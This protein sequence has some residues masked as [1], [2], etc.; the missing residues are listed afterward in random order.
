MHRFLMIL[1]TALV[2]AVALPGYA[3]D[4]PPPLPAVPS[5][6][7]VRSLDE[8]VALALAHAP[9]LQAG[10]AGIGAAEGDRLQA[11]LL[12][13]PEFSIQAENFA[14][15]SNY[16]GFRSAESTIGLAQRI[17]LGGKRSARVEAANAGLSLARQD[18]DLVRLD[19]IRDVTRA[20][21]DVAAAARTVG[22]AEEQHR[23][24]RE[25]LR[26][27]TLKVDAGQEPLIQRRKA[28]VALSTAGIA[29]NKARQEQASAQRQLFALMGVPEGQV[30]PDQGTFEMLEVPAATGAVDTTPD[31]TR[32]DTA[33]VRSRA[34]L[35]VEQAKRYPDVTVGAGMRRFEDDN[36]T[37]FVLSLSVPLQVFD[38]NQ[39]T[40]QR[41]RNELLRTEAE[42]RQARQTL[43]ARFANLQAQLVAAR[44]EADLLRD[45]TLPAAE[46]AFDFARKGYEA[47]KFSLLEVLDAQRALF[48]AR[49]QRTAALR[50]FHLQRAEF[51]RLLAT[52]AASAPPG[53]MP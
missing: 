10:R 34:Q 47:G 27:A 7:P 33:L 40:R 23:L 26:V 37:A 17:E 41:A 46:Q 48:E 9:V 51:N 28:E 31:Y 35:A 36:A 53:G 18:L 14:G 5:A 39:G 32:W 22:L 11:G 49:A 44:D 50:E 16:R 52:P 6:G 43:A 1:A 13:N 19:L 3:A 25:L 29:R 4:Q 20:Y 38:S 8:A 2:W 21:A 24:A 45:E 30:A 15:S 42:A 12:P